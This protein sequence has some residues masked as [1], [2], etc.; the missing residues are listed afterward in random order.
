MVRIC[1]MSARHTY[2]FKYTKCTKLSSR[3]SA[4][5]GSV[6]MDRR[7][8]RRSVDPGLSEARIHM[9]LNRPFATVQRPFGQLLLD[10]SG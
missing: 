4:K 9:V 2:Y 6:T 3:V 5:L 7:R 8:R 10:R 1:L